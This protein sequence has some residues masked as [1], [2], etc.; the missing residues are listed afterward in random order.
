MAG[1]VASE[2]GKRVGGASLVENN[3]PKSESAV[4]ILD[5][6]SDNTEEDIVLPHNSPMKRAMTDSPRRMFCS[7]FLGQDKGSHTSPHTP[8][9]LSPGSKSLDRVLNRISS[10]SPQTGQREGVVRRKLAMEEHK[11]VVSEG[12]GRGRDRC[13]G[14]WLWSS[15]WGGEVSGEGK[16][17]RWNAEPV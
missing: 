17:G 14:S 2:E 11:A 13:A 4:P 6:L 1:G 3:V 16:E 15:G 9:T 5:T 7:S 10:M 8:H 12:R